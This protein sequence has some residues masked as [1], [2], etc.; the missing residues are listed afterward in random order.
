[1]IGLLGIR[2]TLHLRHN[3][4]AVQVGERSFDVNGRPRHREFEPRWELWDTDAHGNEYRVMTLQSPEGGYLP[5]GYWLV[6]LVRLIDPARYG[7]NLDKMIEALVDS[8]NTRLDA[9][10]K[11]SYEDLV[12]DFA[13]RFWH[14]KGTRISVPRSLVTV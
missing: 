11:G 6:E 10:S 4:A 3:P 12:E 5:P 13:E 2:Q 9:L 1:M 8:P 7:G 14:G